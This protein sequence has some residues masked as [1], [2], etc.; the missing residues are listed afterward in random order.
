MGIN[1]KQV[2]LENW[3][4]LNNFDFHDITV[5]RIKNG[6]IELCR[7]R[8]SVLVSFILP[9]TEGHHDGTCYRY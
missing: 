8:S 1:P 4:N 6:S 3:I 7:G 5:F 2:I 9:C